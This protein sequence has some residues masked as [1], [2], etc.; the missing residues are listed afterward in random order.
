M[1]RLPYVDPERA[2]QPVREALQ[3][4]PV[5]L[6]IFGMMA[7]AESSFRPLLRLGASILAGQ[8]LDAKLRELAVLQAARLTPGEYEWIQHVP[9]ARAT[10]ATEAQ[11]EAL[12][13]G[14]YDAECFDEEERLV[15]HFGADTLQG[16]R[17]PGD[18]RADPGAG[19]LLDA[20]PL[21]GGHRH[22][23]RRALRHEGGGR[24][25]R[26]G[27]GPTPATLPAG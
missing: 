15:L 7:H 17:V 8:Q 22:R 21:D 10:G 6:K 19:L 20:R 13:R 1:A 25:R 14:D 11:I 5:P 24:P 9:I 23:P 12:E 16:A 3:A 4:L 26:R 27:L 2:S 18:R